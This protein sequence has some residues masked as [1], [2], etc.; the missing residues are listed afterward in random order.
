MNELDCC[1]EKGV[2]RLIIMTVVGTVV[3]VLGIVSAF[4]Y[5]MI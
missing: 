3:I 5:W 1:I 2:K 4:V